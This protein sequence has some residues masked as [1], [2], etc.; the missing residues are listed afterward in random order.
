[1]VR[2]KV[3]SYVSLLFAG[4]AVYLNKDPTIFIATMLI[5]RAMMEIV[6]R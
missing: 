4:I 5:I 1:M 3:L 6:R 2:L